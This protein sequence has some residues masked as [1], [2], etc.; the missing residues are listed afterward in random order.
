MSASIASG[1][2][3][4]PLGTIQPD[5]NSVPLFKHNIQVILE[6]VIDLQNIARQTLRAIQNAYHPGSLPAQTA[7]T[8]AALKQNLELLADSSA[9]NGVGALPVLSFPHVPP[10]NGNSTDP[11]SVPPEDQMITDATRSIQILFERLKRVQ[12]GASNVANLLLQP[13]S[14]TT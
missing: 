5:L 6:S 7:A 9:H 8:I 2:S 14:N 13:T 3:N 12:D 1:H 11:G 10:S 4:Q